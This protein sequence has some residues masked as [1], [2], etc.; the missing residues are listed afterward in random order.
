MN[1]YLL[2]RADHEIRE[3]IRLLALLPWNTS[4]FNSSL[5]QE[6]HEAL[7]TVVEFYA[8]FFIKIEML[9]DLHIH[10]VDDQSAQTMQLDLPQ[11]PAIRGSY[12][13]RSFHQ[14]RIKACRAE[15]CIGIDLSGGIHADR[16]TIGYRLSIDMR[17]VDFDLRGLGYLDKLLQAYLEAEVSDLD[18]MLLRAGRNYKQF[19]RDCRR[20]FG[21]SLHAFSVKI[22]MLGALRDILFTTATFKEVATA[23]SFTGYKAMYEVFTKQYGLSM[24]DIPRLATQA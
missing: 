16:Q 5:D 2:T 8:A 4:V 3:V 10:A 1:I 19:R 12:T 13:I 22:K 23:N 15:I 24:Q 21:S 18:E 7:Q 6:L 11:E 20:Y 14:Y 17:R 9:T